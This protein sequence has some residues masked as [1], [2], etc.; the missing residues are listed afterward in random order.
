M[1]SMPPATTRRPKSRDDFE[2]AII[3]ALTLEADAVIASFDHHWDEDNGPSFGKARGDPNSYST[4]VIGSHNVVLAH[5][6]G[7]GKVAAGNIAAFCRM[8]FPNIILALVVGICGGAPLY[9]DTPIFLG[10]VIISTGVVQYDFGRRFPDKF[11]MKDTLSE[12]LGR[13][14][15]E[16][17]SLLAKLTTA[18]QRQK[19]TRASRD[20]VGRVPDTYPGRSRDILF[21]AGYRHKHQDSRECTVCA[22]CCTDAD[23]ICSKALKAS[24]EELGCDIKQAVRQIPGN[25]DEREPSLMIHFGTFASGDTVMKSG[26]DRDQL[27]REKN[28]IGFEMESVGVWEVFP[29]IVIKSVCD[30][31]DSHKNKDWQDYSAVCAA[32]C[33]KAFLGY[34]NSTKRI[35]DAK[36]EEEELQ[37]RILKSLHFPEMNQR[38][39][40]VASEAPSTLKWIFGG[41]RPQTFDSRS[42]D[43]GRSDNDSTEAADGSTDQDSDLGEHSD[44][45]G[46]SHDCY[47]KRPRVPK[48]LNVD[49]H[50]HEHETF[51]PS[52]TEKDG[53]NFKTWLTSDQLIYWISGKPGS[54]KSTL[55]KFLLSDSRTLAA[56]E[57]WHEDVVI[58]SHFFW[59]PGSSMQ[60]SFKGLICSI[61]YQLLS[62]DPNLIGYLHDTTATF[63]KSSPSDWDQDQLCKSLYSYQDQTSQTIC[64]FVDALDEARP[65][66]DTLDTLQFIKSM[67]SPKTK[68][69]V[70]SRPEPLFKHQ[71][72]RYP[73]LQMHEL[74]RLDIFEYSKANLRQLTILDSQEL[75]LSE[76]AWKVAEL[77]EG[78]FLWAVLVTQSLVRGLNNGDSEQE[79]EQRLNDMPKDLM[80]LYRDILRRSAEDLLIYRKYVST[81]IN[82][83]RI[84]FTRKSPFSQV[85]AFDCMMVM[86]PDLLERYAVLGD[87]VPNAELD[88][89]TEV[90][91]KRLNSGCP[92]ILGVIPSS[93]AVVFTHRSAEE[94]IFETEEGQRLWQPYRIPRAELLCRSFKAIVAMN[95][96]KSIWDS[97]DFLKMLYEW[98]ESQEFPPGIYGFFLELTLGSYKKGFISPPPANHD[99]ELGPKDFVGRFMLS[100]FRCGHRPFVL[101]TL[102]TLE[103]CVSHDTICCILDL[104]CN[105]WLRLGRPG[106]LY[107]IDNIFE[108]GYN[109]NWTMRRTNISHPMGSLW[110]RSLISILKWVIRQ[111]T[112]HFYEL[113]DMNP[114]A[115]G[116]FQTFRRAGAHIAAT[117]PIYLET[118]TPRYRINT[119]FRPADALGP[120]SGHSLLG[121]ARFMI[122]EIDARTLMDYIMSWTH[123]DTILVGPPTDPGSAAYMKALAFGTPTSRHLYIVESESISARLVKAAEAAL[124]FRGARSI[125]PEDSLKEI[126]DRCDREMADLRSYCGQTKKDYFWQGHRLWSPPV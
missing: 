98:D 73:H 21:P 30:Y 80:S 72:S 71:F 83:M 88:A 16:I 67:V 125:S 33:T 46:D 114:R 22:S 1:P 76:L 6:P 52:L 14:N 74:T 49:N 69:C 95:R 93:W 31:A 28:V 105:E 90:V 3:C 9:E 38:R 84:A 104:I 26:K 75:D 116:I 82:L 32:A 27:I 61:A 40:I 122:I 78:I 19:M 64:I 108:Q 102:K 85:T 39:S 45:V 43:G 77:A 12:S 62:H 37:E 50:S 20:F 110:F 100:A 123:Q 25:K 56:L 92:G 106:T 70:S 58:V 121:R 5:L 87:Q 113:Y 89:K 57:K 91:R 94:F 81:A 47:E 17:R 48:H 68:I 120:G 11:E 41:S 51:E 60:K 65:G 42:S 18:R 29:C 119:F 79:I 107:M 55:M 15:L 117:F 66:Q 54:G 115:T 10:D 7:M 8:S 2:I 53:G 101:G 44:E 126:L 13:P 59:K 109:P 24:C 35:I 99:S 111:R 63:R 4:G 34:W 112:N 103:P 124:K 118:E 86:E 36:A 23:T 96:F 97:E